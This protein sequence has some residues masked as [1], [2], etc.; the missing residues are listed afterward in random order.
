MKNSEGMVVDASHD[1]IDL[2]ETLDNCMH[3]DG[4]DQKGPTDEVWS[5]TL[6]TTACS[7]VPS[8]F[9]K[10]YTGN[11]HVLPHLSYYWC[12]PFY[13]CTFGNWT[14]RACTPHLTC[15]NINYVHELGEGRA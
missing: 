5:T 14:L 7:I 4:E 9:A 1:P 15:I 11:V 2:K 12:M 10:R 13:H 8:V 6:S 3:Q